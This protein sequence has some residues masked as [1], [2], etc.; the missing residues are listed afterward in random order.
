MFSNGNKNRM[1]LQ[2]NNIS[3]SET[4]CYAYTEAKI[5][6]SLCIILSKYLEIMIFLVFLNL[7]FFSILGTVR[8]PFWFYHIWHAHLQKSSI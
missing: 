8:A 1:M 4:L 6:K 3:C 2:R 7:F 5:T